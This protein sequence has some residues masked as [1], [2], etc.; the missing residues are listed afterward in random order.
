MSTTRDLTEIIQYFKNDSGFERLMS[1]MFDLYNRYGRCFSA[2][3]LSRPT[4]E[5]E[6]ALST[7]FNRDYYDQMLIR[8][9]LAEFERQVHKVFKYEVALPSIL[10]AYLGRQLISQSEPVSEIARYKD[11]FTRTI[12]DDILPKYEDTPAG[13]WLKEMLAHMRRTYRLWADQF[14]HEPENVLSMISSVCEAFNALPPAGHLVRL[15]DFSVQLMGSSRALDFYS[16]L[17]PLFLRALAHRHEG[18]VPAVLEDSIRLYLQAGLLSDGVLSQVTVRGIKAE[19]DACIFY[20]Q[21]GEAHVLTLENICRIGSASAYGDKIFVIESPHVFSALCERLSGQNCT[22]VCASFGLNPALEHLLELCTQSGAVIYY[23]GN[24]D[25][26]GLTLADKVYL[27]FGKRFVPWRYGKADYE[28][29]FA[30][31]DYLLPDD[32]KDLAMHNEELASLLSL[33]RKKG[34]S[35]SSL[36]LVGLLAEDIRAI[37]GL[38]D[39]DIGYSPTNISVQ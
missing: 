27:R 13:S 5:E 38:E 32:R 23:A 31:G 20:D 26:K 22:L 21:L 9:G 28:L 1:G 17:G 25:Y 18:P 11:A 35:A 8:I 19:D 14:A 3:R 33:L 2:V 37:L 10:E 36:P 16:P 6:N 39:D 7:F 4:N 24:M 29:L 34:K 12:R 30:G 15:S